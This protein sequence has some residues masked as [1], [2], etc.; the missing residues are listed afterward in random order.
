MRRRLLLA[1]WGFVLGTGTATAQLPPIPQAPPLPIPPRTYTPTPNLPS[2]GIPGR[3]PPLNPALPVQP[4][5]PGAPQ[6]PGLYPPGSAYPFPNAPRPA[7]IAQPQDIPLPAPET[8]FSINAVDVTLKRISGT[9]QLWAG[10]KML[11][12]FGDRELDARDA[13]RVYRDLRPT[14]WVTI[15]GPKPIVEYALVN[16]RPAMTLGAG[17][18]D[19][20]KGPLNGKPVNGSPMAGVSMNPNP[21]GNAATGGIGSGPAATGAGAKLVV[22]ID[23]K[24]VRVEAVRGVWCLRDDD[25]IHFNFGPVKA[26]AEQALAAVRRYGF[27]RIGVVGF[28]T[29]M[30][31]FFFVG[32]E[33]PATPKGPLAQAA[34][35]GQ[36]DGLN[37]VGIPVPGVGYVGEMLRFDPKKLEVRK[38]GAEWVVAAGM[39][40][41]GRYGATEFAARDAARTMTDA[42]FTEFCRVGSGGLSFFL[43]NG[44]TP[45]R[46]PFAAQGRRF[47]LNALKVQPFGAAFAITENGRHLLDCATAEEG[48]TLIR[49]VKHFGFD[50][51]CHLGPTPKLGVSFLAKGQ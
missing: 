3:L 35:Q 37:R 7:P 27:N 11:R 32:P 6:S 26:D 1:Q 25:N 18:T 10:Q 41:I 45:T 23:L 4:G 38:D 49:V 46:V 51:L 19:E 36:I 39:E 17:G 24:S 22:P 16:G 12:D 20:Q 43:V 34:L 40:V 15:G 30:M 31:S 28:P 47:D 21:M 5:M 14:E 8:K 50:Q 13:L 33:G 2:P 48:E 9:W 42:R 29:P 44:K